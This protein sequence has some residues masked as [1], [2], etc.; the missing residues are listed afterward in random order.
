M[1]IQTSAVVFRGVTTILICLASTSI[2]AEDGGRPSG[3]S[4]EEQA[5]SPLPFEVLVNATG[6]TE[7]A[8]ID[9]LQLGRKV[10]RPW[11]ACVAA[12][13]YLR[14]NFRASPEVFLLTAQN[15]LLTGDLRT[16]A[17]HYESAVKRMK[18]GPERDDAAAELLLILIDFLGETDDAY[19][20]MTEQG[21][22][23]RGSI[24]VRKFDAWYLDSTR[25]PKAVGMTN[26]LAQFDPVAMDAG[27]FER[28]TSLGTTAK[29]QEFFQRLKTYLDRA[30]V[31]PY[32]VPP[33]SMAALKSQDSLTREE[34][35]QLV[36]VFSATAPEVWAKDKQF[37]VL[38][39]TLDAQADQRRSILP[40]LVPHFWKVARDTGDSSLESYLVRRAKALLDQK[41]PQGAVTYCLA[42]QQIVHRWMAEENRQMLQGV[43]ARARASLLGS[44]T[45]DKTDRKYP[46]LAAQVAFLSD[47]FDEAWEGA[48]RNPGLLVEMCRGMDPSFCCW[49]MEKHT[50][51]RMFKDAEELGRALITWVD[52]RGPDYDPETRVCLYLAYA[53][54]SLAKKAYPEARAQF[55]RIAGMSDLTGTIAQRMAE[56]RLAEVDR[57]TKN[58]DKAIERLEKLAKR[59]DKFT[60]VEANYQLAMVKYD[61]AQPKTPGASPDSA[62]LKEALQY[63]ETI[64]LTSP[65]HVEANILW[66]KCKNGLKCYDDAKSLSCLAYALPQPGLRPDSSGSLGEDSGGLDSCE[67]WIV[68]K[69]GITPAVKSKD[70]PTQGE[71]RAKVEGKEIPFPLKHTAV[72]A[73]VSAFIASVDVTQQYENPYDTKIEAVYVFPLPESS[74]VT[75]FVMTI[76]DRHIRGMVR[77]RKEAEKLYAQAKAQGYRAALLTQERPNIFTQKVANIDPGKRIDVKIVYFNPLPYHDGEYE[78]VFPMVVGPRFN[79]SGSTDGVGAV[80]RGKTGVSGQST[81]VEYLKP[82]ERNGHDI[83]LSVDIDA[84]MKIEKVHSATHAIR[85]QK[86]S[87]SRAVVQLSPN[88]A[89]PNKDFVLRYKVAGK[90]MKTAMLVHRTEKENTFALVLQP[91]EDTQTVDRMPREM[92]FVLD[93]SGSMSGAPIAKSKKA[94]ERCLRNLKENDTFQIIEFSI[95]A[96]QFG[97]APVPATPENI[98]KGLAYLGGLNG[99]G[100]TMMITG[101]KAALE[102]PHDEERLRIVTFLT[103]GYIGNEA[104][105][106]KAAKERLGAS[107]IFSFGI[108][109]SVNRY[110]IEGLASFGKGAVAYVG[111]DE[112]AGEKVDLFFERVARPALTDIRIDWDGMKVSDVYPKEIPD[113]FVGRPVMITGRFQG[114]GRQTIKVAGR[115]GTARTSYDVKVD[116][117]DKAIE[118]PAITSLWAR[119]KIRDLSEQ[120]ILSEGK[121]LKDQIIATSIAY[122]L[123]SRHTAFL[124]AD[125]TE[126]TGGGQAKT[127]NVPVP[128]PEGVKYKTTVQE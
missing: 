43:L 68:E 32:R 38:V 53:D 98:E 52:E 47:R 92:V 95:S 90:S 39:R 74:A 6:V 77:E 19:R 87:D 119:W 58:Y 123:L 5:F 26:N 37:D 82:G 17:R 76:G 29:R 124:A 113:V 69:S 104:E 23:I 85:T 78:F 116:L 67:V 107:R 55:E 3:S 106:L 10:G 8:V 11:V 42:G 117:G 13:S 28:E 63:V 4:G 81:E 57:L 91:P 15:A 49:V 112:S 14:Q 71:L 126:S 36:K 111:L 110:L 128:V 44:P 122:N 9:M 127:V 12:D 75:D 109:T 120:A 73:R 121:D 51:T 30:A 50:Q 56:L 96:S 79:P 80:A 102:F 41:T 66:G 125:G 70:D 99:E 34:A 115:S 18:P 35:D 46:I 48:Q 45:L 105:I 7:A 114:K 65:G 59:P 86:E 101:V 103:D 54:L 61:Q 64:F 2:V 24:G 40:A 83:S 16:A 72:N 21:E 62:L 84:G 27:Y 22:T 93:C 31:A 33:P 94:V 118:H 108:G 88:D 25:N 97:N 1:R 20:F 60:R 89:I 100:G